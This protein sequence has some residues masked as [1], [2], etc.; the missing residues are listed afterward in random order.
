MNL[1]NQCDYYSIKAVS[2]SQIP[3]RKWKKS[4]IATVLGFYFDLWFYWESR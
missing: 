1:Q 2:E 4:L 3:K